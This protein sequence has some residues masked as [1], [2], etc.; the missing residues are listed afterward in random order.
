MNKPPPDPYRREFTVGRVVHQA[1]RGFRRHFVIVT[2]ICLA[3]GIADAMVPSLFRP[4]SVFAASSHQALVSYLLSTAALTF[5][6]TPA[7]LVMLYA[8]QERPIWFREIAGLTVRRC[9]ILVAFQV[10]ITAIME[11]PTDWVMDGNEK[12]L[13]KLALMVV[14]LGYMAVLFALNLV[15][16]PALVIEPKGHLY[17]LDNAIR[18][19]SRH[20]L[21]LLIVS[22]MVALAGWFI[23]WCVYY[24]WDW[25]RY[26]PWLWAGTLSPFFLHKATNA[27]GSGLQLLIVV[28]IATAIYHLLHRAKYGGPPGEMAR[29][30]D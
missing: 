18:L 30:F 2:S 10:A 11:I 7:I 5:V 6:V 21:R 1:W 14:L 19:S 4:G 23:A 24:A 3:A 17:A 27:V 25:L 29:V 13:I 26:A 15:L 12:P 8:H 16:M 28:P 20:W 22:I 9:T